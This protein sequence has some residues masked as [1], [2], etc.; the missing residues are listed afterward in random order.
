MS[1]NVSRREVLKIS[2]ALGGAG[3]LSSVLAACGG[4]TSGSSGGGAGALTI[5]GIIPFTGLETHNGLSM[6][7]G[8]EM[9]ADEINSASGLAGQKVHLQLLDA[10]GDV[11]KGV[12]AAQ[13]LINQDHVALIN[14][15]LTSSVRSAVFQVTKKTGTLFM[16]PTFYEGGLCDRSYFSTGAP[17]NQTIDPL[18]KYAMANLG[19]SVYFIGSDYIW[20]TGSISAG[21]SAVTGAG[22][23]VVGTPAVVPL[24]TTDFSAQIRDIQSLKPDIVWPFVAGQD[25]ITFLKQLN[26]AGVRKQVKIVADYIDELIVPALSPDVYTGIVNCSTYFMSLETPAN[27]AFLQKMRGKYGQD[28]KISSF[29]MNMYNNMKLLEAA[30]KGMKTWDKAKV[31]DAL[32]SA[33]FDGPSGALKFNPHSHYATSDAYIAEIQGDASFKI[34][35]TEKQVAPQ[36]MCSL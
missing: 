2:A 5:G 33:S 26:D 29:G 18:A 1:S 34:V 21:K 30:T 32:S 3:I 11:N 16:N 25:G 4:S 19:K 22:G 24:G 15:T 35:Q 27:T 31:I 10:G 8:I 12:Q 6:K 9:A 13:Q 17:P 14:G 7:Y 23:R 28:A 20:G 36:A